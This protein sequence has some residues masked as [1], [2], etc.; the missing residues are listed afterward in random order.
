MILSLFLCQNINCIYRL[1]ILLNRLTSGVVIIINDQ[2]L[3][4]SGDCYIE[5]FQLCAYLSEFS[6]YFSPFTFQTQYS[7]VLFTFLSYCI[8]WILDNLIC[9]IGHCIY[10]LLFWLF[11]EFFKL[12]WSIAKHF[13]VFIFI[14]ILIDQGIKI[15]KFISM[16]FDQVSMCLHVI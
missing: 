13:N 9:W 8:G 7:L 15:K 5:K 3:F 6:V 14:L 10:L 4:R 1:P 12:I 16:N 11:S 2:I